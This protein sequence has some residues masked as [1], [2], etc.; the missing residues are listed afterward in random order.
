MK[1]V[2]IVCFLLGFMNSGKSQQTWM[3]DSIFCKSPSIQRI[4]SSPEK[5]KLQ[6]ICTEVKHTP[7]GKIEFI[8]HPYHVADTNYFYPAS[9]VKLP[10]SIFAIEK[11]NALKNDLIT[12]QTEIHIDSTFSCQ[13][14]FLSDVYSNDSIQTLGNYIE[15]AL[16]VSDNPSYSRLYEFVGPTYFAHRFREMNM[17]RSVIRHRF[18]SCDSTANRHTNPFHF[19]SPFGDTIYTQPADFYTEPYGEPIKSML[20]GK[21]HESNGRVIPKPKSFEKSNALPLNDIHSMLMELIY[22]ESQPFDFFISNEQRLFLIDMITRMPRQ[23]DNSKI[24]HNKDFHDNYTNYLFFGQENKQRKSNLELSNIVGLAYGFMTDVCYVKDT[25]T[26][27][28][29]FLSATLYLNSSNKFG[30]GDYQYSTLG[31][32]FM[33]ELGWAVKE[34]LEKP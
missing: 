8:Y 29:F 10:A 13:N 34:E 14:K 26:G 7:N 11:L 9:I 6:I 21:S 20:V 23:A 3:W 30:S 28:E 17:K 27:T 18:S 25:Q 32:P 5:Y 2:F 31:F 33:K 15:K 16:I 12:F 24:A 19:I 4:T 22:P 1:W